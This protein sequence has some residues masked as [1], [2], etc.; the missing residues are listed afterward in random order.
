MEL[1][2][3]IIHVLDSLGTNG[4]WF[5]FLLSVFQNC[6][7]F[8]TISL[9]WFSPFLKETLECLPNFK[10][11]TNFKKLLLLVFVIWL[12]F[13]KHFTW[14]DEKTKK[15]MGGNSVCKL[16]FQIPKAKKSNIYQTI[17]LISQLCACVSILE[18]KFNAL[19]LNLQFDLSG[20]LCFGFFIWT[21]NSVINSYF[22]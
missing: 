8:L 13:W 6:A 17:F 12:Q 20:L 5:R 2:H 1:T 10:T 21:I 14:V 3:K 9:L 22:I 18:R 7:Y 16:N 15:L 4:Y 19:L 11:K